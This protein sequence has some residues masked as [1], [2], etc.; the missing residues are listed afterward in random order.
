VAT[1]SDDFRKFGKEQFETVNAAA[2]SLVKGLQTI[3][4]ENADY[5]KRSLQTST[6]YLEKLAGAKSLDDAVQNQAEY[7]KAACDEF[8]SQANKVG[9]LYSNFAKEAFKPVE[10]VITKVKPERRATIRK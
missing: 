5:A 3:A 1:N 9:E 10:S 6:T 4:A 2:A 7:A 8:F